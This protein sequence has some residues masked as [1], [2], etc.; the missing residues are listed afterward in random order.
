MP[1]AFITLGWWLVPVACLLAAVV[2]ATVALEA[3][4]VDYI[5]PASLLCFYS[6]LFLA[7][8]GVIWTLLWLTVPHFR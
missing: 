7:V 1:L 4:R 6:C 3:N 2:F 8:T 5:E